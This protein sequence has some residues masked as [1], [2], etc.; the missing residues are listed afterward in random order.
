MASDHGTASRYSAKCRCDA[1]RAAWAEYMRDYYARHPGLRYTQVL[2][3]RQ[4][5]PEKHRAAKRRYVERHPEANQKKNAG[6]RARKA[7]V[8]REPYTRQD[9]YDRDEG[10]CH[11]CGVVAPPEAFHLDH[12]VPLARG[13]PDTPANVKVAHD[14][15]NGRK[16]SLLLEEMT[17]A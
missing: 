3:W 4:R 10:I 16:G 12:V 17:L 11:I 2:D 9:I 7:G 14:A 6:R 15:C 13:G 8:P 5:N 1:C